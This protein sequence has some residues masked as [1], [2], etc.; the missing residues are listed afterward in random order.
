MDLVAYWARI[1]TAGIAAL[2]AGALTLTLAACGGET[3][4]GNTGGNPTATTAPKESNRVDVGLDEWLID[5]KA[6]QIPAGNTT[7][8]AKNVG[9]FSHN[10]VV[11]KDGKDIGGTPP[12]TPGESPKEVTLDLQPGTYTT[13]C[14]IPGHAQQGMVG[15]LTVSP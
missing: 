9:E 5:P 13:I 15:T 10:F 12:F 14:T 8:V 7:F 3:N 2:V 4:T 11:Q 1:K 6:L